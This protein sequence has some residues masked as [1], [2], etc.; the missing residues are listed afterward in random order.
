MIKMYQSALLL[1]SS[2]VQQ[3][4]YISTSDLSSSLSSPIP[5]LHCGQFGQIPS[6]NHLIVWSFECSPRY[7]SGLFNFNCYGNFVLTKTY[8]HSY[9]LLLTNAALAI[10]W[11]FGGHF[12][13]HL[14]ESRKIKILYPHLTHAGIIF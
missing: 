6:R 1:G 12:I 2:W 5:P 9:K 4:I 7:D 14:Q 11:D 13:S 10:I 3:R 8:H